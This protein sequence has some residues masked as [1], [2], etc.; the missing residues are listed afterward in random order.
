MVFIWLLGGILFSS[1][2]E[3]NNFLPNQGTGMPWREQVKSVGGLKT[4]DN[5]KDFSCLSVCLIEVM[6]VS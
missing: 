3:G 5:Q 1:V 4:R 6:T 2:T